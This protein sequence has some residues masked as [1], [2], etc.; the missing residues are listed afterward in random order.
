MVLYPTMRERY[1]KI[2]ENFFT[3]KERINLD[4]SDRNYKKLESAFKVAVQ[5]RSHLILMNNAKD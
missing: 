4:P 2:A 1:E 5:M 3:K